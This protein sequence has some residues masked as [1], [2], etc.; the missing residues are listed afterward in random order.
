MI[1]GAPR[2]PCTPIT[3]LFIQ[4]HS[5][6]INYWYS[7]IFPGSF[8]TLTPRSYHIQVRYSRLP[9]NDPR[10]LPKVLHAQ[11]ERITQCRVYVKR[12][13]ILMEKQGTLTCPAASDDSDIETS[14][15]VNNK[16]GT[17]AVQPCA[18]L[19]DIDVLDKDVE[20]NTAVGGGGW[21]G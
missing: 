15:P 3:K 1:F 14:S 13:T 20:R 2:Y 10:E 8:G 19:A 9:G 17:N 5:A 6:Y 16:R 21:S 18:H 7:R 11:E 4:T 12:T